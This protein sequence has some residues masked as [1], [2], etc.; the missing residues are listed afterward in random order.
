[1]NMKVFLNKVHKQSY[2]RIALVKSSQV[3]FIYIVSYD[4]SQICLQGLYNLTQI[5]KNSPK[6]PFN[7]E[8]NADFAISA[9]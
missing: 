9:W 3:N 7:S 1:M 4:T 2:T 5:R 6:K 8:K